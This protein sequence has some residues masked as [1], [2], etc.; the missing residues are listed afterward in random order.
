MVVLTRNIIITQFNKKLGMT[1]DVILKT[2]QGLITEGQCVITSKFDAGKKGV[3]YGGAR[4]TGVDLQSFSKWQAGCKNLVRLLGD[5]AEPWKGTFEG[6]NSFNNAT[7]MLG[8]VEAIEQLVTEGLL[9]EIEDMV[10]GRVF[11]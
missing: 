7:R 8:T 9:V 1:K 6:D 10:Q 11:H 4:P 3:M 5:S 2:V